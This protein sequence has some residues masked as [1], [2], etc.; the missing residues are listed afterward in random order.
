[1]KY[2]KTMLKGYWKV[3]SL[4]GGALLTYALA[5]FI[6]FFIIYFFILHHD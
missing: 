5:W 4:L 6:Y 2:L 1:M 3:V